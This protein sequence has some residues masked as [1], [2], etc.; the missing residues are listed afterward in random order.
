[1]QI[2]MPPFILP[3]ILPPNSTSNAVN[4]LIDQV[5]Y[6]LGRLELSTARRCLFE[7]YLQFQIN[8]ALVEEKKSYFH[9]M[10]GYILTLMA[11]QQ[12]FGELFQQSS[13]SSTNMTLHCMQNAALSYLKAMEL[14]ELKSSAERATPR[15]YLSSLYYNIGNY[16]R[17][18]IFLKQAE[19][20]SLGTE[21]SHSVLYLISS[22]NL[23]IVTLNS[24]LQYINL[25]ESPLNP[26]RFYEPS[27]T[28]NSQKMSVLSHKIT[29]NPRF[30]GTNFDQSKGENKFY[31]L[32]Q[33]NT[34]E[35]LQS[36]LFKLGSLIDLT[37]EKEPE[38]A[39][40]WQKLFQFTEH[41]TKSFGSEELFGV[42]KQTEIIHQKM[43]QILGNNYMTQNAACLLLNAKELQKQIKTQ[44]EDIETEEKETLTTSKTKTTAQLSLENYKEKFHGIPKRS[45]CNIKT[46]KG[47][48][49]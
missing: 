36:N 11:E 39:G 22:Y 16:E 6:S 30:E 5:H 25:L 2:S 23:C 17:A 10:N 1:M 45:L 35:D 42:V 19:S 41:Y 4:R 12:Q 47:K 38:N 15:I 43:M 13:L 26:H 32:K 18:T 14:I 20:L 49:K 46:K 7:A 31:T 37:L 33:N 29:S 48:K 21:G 9:L 3:Q 28:V 27:S 40:K 8:D 24:Y 44:I 34:S